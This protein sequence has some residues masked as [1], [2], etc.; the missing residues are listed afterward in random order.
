MRLSHCTQVLIAALGIVVAAQSPLL[1]FDAAATFDSAF[2]QQFRA[3]KSTPSKDDDT[4]LAAK[5]LAAARDTTDAA[6]L[7]LLCERASELATTPE[8]IALGVE[9]MQLLVRRVP[10]Q[11]LAALENIVKLRHRGVASATAAQRDDANQE[12]VS[13]MV[14]LAD[15][16]AITDADAGIRTL[17]QALLIA[18]RAKLVNASNIEMQMQLLSKQVR[19]QRQSQQFQKQLLATPDNADLSMRL[20]MLHLIDLDD[21]A[22]ALPFSQ[23][24]GDAKLAALAI[25]AATPPGDL[26]AADLLELAKWYR[27]Q[28]MTTGP[29]G[30][31]E[32]WLRAYQILDA[33]G[34]TKNGSGLA[35]VEGRLLLASTRGELESRGIVVYGDRVIRPTG[36][37]I[38]LLKIADLKINTLVGTWESVRDGSLNTMGEADKDA[39]LELPLEILGSYMASFEFT[40][41]DGD[42]PM[43]LS[44]PVGDRATC[45]YFG[46]QGQHQ[47]VHAEGKTINSEKSG[48]L[49][50]KRRNVVDLLVLADANRGHIH[51]RLNGQL[52]HAWEGEIAGLSP[53]DHWRMPDR[54]MI[55]LAKTGGSFS[56]HQVRLRMIEGLTRQIERT[57]RVG[58]GGG[59]RFTDTPYGSGLLVG[60]RYTTGDYSGHKIIRS[61]QGVFLTP[62]GQRTGPAWGTG[63]NGPFEVM[64]KPGYA[65]SSIAIRG[66]DRL[67][68]FQFSFMKLTP[69]GLDTRDKYDSPWQGGEGG[70]AKTLG[71][72]GQPIV[73]LHGGS[74]QDIDSLGI[75]YAPVQSMTLWTSLQTVMRTTEH[76]PTIAQTLEIVEEPK[77]AA[78]ETKPS[79]AGT[80]ILPDNKGPE[81]RPVTNPAS[82]GKPSFFGIPIE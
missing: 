52:I 65:I 69:R 17:Q 67:D 53:Q 12:L 81:E 11:R 31:D 49:E 54:R 26:A 30:P 2:G 82:K 56:F 80:A 10:D 63:G 61:V 70:G 13:A 38:N 50:N 36:E 62:E 55:G 44:I 18:R 72:N 45:L 47:I 42:G 5:L 22:G 8:S 35:A 4:Q 59:A 19:A 66:G 64:A 33:H 73:G 14:A 23:K 68:G 51:V 71:G 37:W 79:L 16:Q 9:A 46:Y 43:V 27:Q 57:G 20:T 48:P 24:C 15:A 3:A 58:G 40:R 21:P 78:P 32:P 7:G 77:V 75:V 28:A 34:Q 29:R 39:R 25:K 1:A 6:L 74:G 41:S 76:K 60:V